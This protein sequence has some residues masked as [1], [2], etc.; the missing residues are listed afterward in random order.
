VRGNEERSDELKTPSQAA[1][2]ARARTLVQDTTR[3]YLLLQ[4]SPII[5]T[6]F[7]IRFAHR[8]VIPVAEA[9]ASVLTIL[10]TV[11]S[12]I[13][14]NAELN[15]AWRLYKMVVREKSTKNSVEVTQTEERSDKLATTYLVSKSTRARASVQD[16][17][18]P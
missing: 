3:P 8:R 18:P 12:A 14:N 7:A 9:L 1:K 2:T 10:I 17:P 16:A 6:S 4:S 13:S 15:D 5:P 11:D